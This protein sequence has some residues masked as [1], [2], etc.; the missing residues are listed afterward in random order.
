MAGTR[1]TRARRGYP[2]SPSRRTF[3]QGTKRKAR[4]CAGRLRT[5]QWR[6]GAFTMTWKLQFCRSTTL[7][8]ASA[9]LAALALLIVA[10]TSPARADRCDDLA[11][12]LKR[13]IDGLAVSTPA[14]N[15]IFLSHP[16]ASKTHLA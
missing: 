6:K 2:V 14:P 9:L 15:V 10:G 7:A 8:S 13:Q 5:L 1:R 12:Q 4:S 3:P 16:R 11:G